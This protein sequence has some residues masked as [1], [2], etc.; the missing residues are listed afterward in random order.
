[1]KRITFSEAA[2]P[3]H[4]DFVLPGMLAGTVGLIVGQGAVG[5]SF[6]AL[7][8][9]ISVALG[10]AACTGMGDALWPAPAS[11][12]VAIV[13]GEDIPH[14]VHYRLHELRAALSP[15]DLAQIDAELDV[16]SWTD[17]QDDLR[18]IQRQPGGLIGHGPFY[19][20]LRALAEGRRLVILDPL[21][22]LHD[23]DE[24]NNGD[25]TTLMR[26]LG[27]IARATGCAILVLHHIGKS[28]DGDDWERSRGASSLTTAVR[29][30]LNLTVMSEKEADEYG[31][32]DDLERHFYIRLAQV[33]ANYGRP[34][35]PKWLRKQPGGRLMAY[36]L[37]KLG[38]GN[39]RSG[40][41]RRNANPF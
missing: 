32:A 2:E 29:L 11:G 9:G 34:A 18:V 4:L 28:K 26:A 39:H 3:P 16:Q 37:Q 27:G 1:M 10:K 13:M 19:A 24:N 35:E 17:E 23:C 30:Q 31:I 25:M 15:D 33:K 21:A 14:V 41:E 12:P 22:F 6:L 40:K 5:K 7:H 20:K 8:I 36:P 38:K